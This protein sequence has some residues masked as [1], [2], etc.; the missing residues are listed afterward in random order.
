MLDDGNNTDSDDA[1]LFP[2]H[3]NT[4]AYAID[5]LCPVGHRYAY[6][7]GKFCC[8]YSH[9]KKQGGWF[10]NKK[11][12]GS[13]IQID[14]ECCKDDAWVVCPSPPCKKRPSAFVGYPEHCTTHPCEDAPLAPLDCKDAP[15]AAK[16]DSPVPVEENLVEYSPADSPEDSP[17]APKVNEKEEISQGDGTE[18]LANSNN[19]DNSIDDIDEASNVDEDIRVNG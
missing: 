9:E 13:W 7:N 4:E 12:D 3:T 5:N 16:E 17:E 19:S 6:K 2:L 14:S 18:T 10:T 15:V 1:Y 11:C 8:K